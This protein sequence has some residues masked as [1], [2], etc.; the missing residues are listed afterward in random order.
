MNEEYRCRIFHCDVRR[1][2][3]CCHYCPK[4]SQCK[5]P[6]LNHPARCGEVFQQKPKEVQAG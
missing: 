2:R 3:Y 1:D 6:C 5:N 4:R